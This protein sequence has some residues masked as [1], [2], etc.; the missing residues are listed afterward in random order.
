MLRRGLCFLITLVFSA[1]ISFSIVTDFVFAESGSQGCLSAGGVIRKTPYAEMADSDELLEAYFDSQVDKAL[2][3]ST[4]NDS[5]KR[6]AKTPRRSK[7]NN[8][9]KYLYDEILAKME[10]AASGKI[11][12]TE[13]YIDLSVQL[14][15]YLVD[16]DGHKAITSYSLGIS[17][18]VYKNGDLSNE[19]V[20]K[21]FDTGKVVDALLLDNPYPAYWFDKVSGYYSGLNYLIDYGASES[22]IYFKGNPCLYTGFIVAEGYRASGSD[23]ARFNIDKEKAGSTASAVMTVESIV[24]DNSAKNDLEKLYAYK[25][26]ICDLTSYNDDAASDHYMPYGDPWQ[27]IWV[28]DGNDSTNVV[29]EGYSKAFQYLCDKTSFISNSI[30]CR[31]V[32]GILDYGIGSGSH[33][34]NILHMDDGKNYIADITNCD[35]DDPENGA[36]PEELFLKGYFDITNNGGYVYSDGS[37]YEYDANT[38]SQ[39]SEAELAMSANDYGAEGT[40]NQVI[41]IT[42]RPVN[43]SVKL[44]E[45]VNGYYESGVFIYELP[46][47]VGD[48]LDVRYSGTNNMTTYVYETDKNGFGE[49]RAQGS[50]P[51]GAP[52]LI[53]DSD[54]LQQTNQ[55]TGSAWKVGNSYEMELSYL[56][57]TYTLPV[58]I[59][60]GH[61]DRVFINGTEPNCINE[62]ISAHYECKKCGSLLT[63]KG[64]KYIETTE[65]ALRIPATG[66]HT[67][68]NTVYTWNADY[69]EVTGTHTC[70]VCSKSVTAT[71]KRASAKVTKL[72]TS[73]EKGEI[74]YTSEAF[75]EEGFEIQSIIVETDKKQGGDLISAGQTVQ[76]N[77]NTYKVTSVKSKTV[78]FTKAN[79][80]KNIIIP[81]TVKLGD[82]K[83][84][85]VTTIN[86]NAFKGANIRS[87]VIG[88]NV[89]K[90]N[91][92][93]FKGSKVTLVTIKTKL[94]KKVGVNGSLKGSKI[95]TLKIKIGTKTVNKKFVKNY[96]NIFTKANAGKKVTVK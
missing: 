65:D 68:G 13:F 34:W 1:M 88:K 85:K 93:A 73:D 40:T 4:L 30:G 50:V 16:S 3:K 78:A 7:L 67:W 19:A 82:G 10:D 49:F 22:D 59:V 35:E 90:I 38:L 87:V 25:D 27:L 36:Y 72:A 89:R 62:G 15:D 39:Y 31:T 91:K 33:M 5:K 79:N 77:G 42:F 92:N 45:G 76:K 80:A 81:A 20:A 18:P 86:A 60:C 24:E 12:S 47:A 11:S 58:T 17:G 83:N 23:D 14:A 64:V 21:L 6:F 41:G 74:T 52:G 8:I 2:G 37:K 32:T 69:T 94:L 57:C 70:I 96:K 29:C 44:A 71:A 46:F 43:D 84:Y 26:K 51:Y 95:K 9:E 75:A 53:A 48:S 61:N 28:F 54:I 55:N 56:N 66:I 63:K